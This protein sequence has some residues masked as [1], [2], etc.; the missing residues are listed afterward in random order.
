MLGTGGLMHNDQSSWENALVRMPASACSFPGFRAWTHSDKFP[1]EGSIAFIGEEV[2]IDMSPERLDSHN[3]VKTEVMG[4]LR[5][6]VVEDDLGNLSSDRTRVV[7]EAVLLSNA[8]DGVFGTW[9]TI[10]YAKL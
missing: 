6:V 5:N 2:F 8:P 3:K 9:L 4:V 7:N 10:E 1:D